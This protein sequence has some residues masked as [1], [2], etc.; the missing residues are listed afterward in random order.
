MSD[1]CA[2]SYYGGPTSFQG[3]KII[4]FVNANLKMISL[5]HAYIRIK[6]KISPFNL[7]PKAQMETS[8]RGFHYLL[9]NS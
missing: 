8:F 2:L 7:V 3:T 1:S 6:Q 4:I 9:N 5:N